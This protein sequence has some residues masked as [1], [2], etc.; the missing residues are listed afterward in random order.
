[1]GLHVGDDP[2]NVR[3]N[4]EAVRKT[5]GVSEMIFMNQVHGDD[6]VYV[7]KTTQTP[8]CDAIISNQK[9]LALAVMV[10]DCIPILMY[11]ERTQSI[12]AVHA[13]RKGT[14]LN[15]VSK[16]LNA[17]QEHFGVKPEEV[18]VYMGASIGA[19]C[20][21]VGIE[22]TKGLEKVLHVKNNRFF[23][24]LPLANHSALLDAGIKAKHIHKEAICTC[25]DIRYFSY[26]RE[27]QT[28]RFVGVI[29]L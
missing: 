7:D 29:H 23:L 13:G 24:D 28:G 3:A 11:D 2:A 17:M 14:Q 27:H 5:L 21:E 18:N 16:T 25:C 6:V 19:C 12:A 4:R 1:M 22:V 15:I 20:Y 9:G 8:N 26:R 10:A